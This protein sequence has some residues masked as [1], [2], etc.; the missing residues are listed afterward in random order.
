MI[1]LKQRAQITSLIERLAP[2]SC[3]SALETAINLNRADIVET[4]LSQD[5]EESEY[6]GKKH[7]TQIAK[8]DTGEMGEMAFGFKARKVNMMRGN[9]QGNN[10][11]LEDIAN[12]H[13]TPIEYLLK[14]SHSWFTAFGQGTV[15][16]ETL[17][18]IGKCLGQD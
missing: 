6:R 8:F 14:Q 11:F 3:Y 2:E 12:E 16:L 1:C 4:M 15:K 5:K 17:R 7:A 18:A 9:R 10:A 13:K